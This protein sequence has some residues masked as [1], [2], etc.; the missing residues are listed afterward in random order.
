MSASEFDLVVEQFHRAPE[1]VVK[2]DA[3]PAR[4][5]YSRSA[6][7]LERGARSY[8]FPRLCANW[9]T[10]SSLIRGRTRP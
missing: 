3:G 9:Q 2:G 8:S 10:P 1:A 7:D 4:A 5:L 6:D